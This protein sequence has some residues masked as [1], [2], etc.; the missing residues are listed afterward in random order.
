MNMAYDIE[1][2][3]VV[4]A[5]G[6]ARSLIMMDGWIQGQSGGSDCGWCL[7]GACVS[8]ARDGRLAEDA[9]ILL[10]YQMPPEYTRHCIGVTALVKWN[11]EP[12]RTK[13]DVISM[14]DKALAKQGA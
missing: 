5:L 9:M 14:L 12:E 4:A 11:D 10:S 7:A 13:A 6:R 8:A 3:E 1:R 2:K